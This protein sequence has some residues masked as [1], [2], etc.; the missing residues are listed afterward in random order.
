MDFKNAFNSYLP[1]EKK[2][3]LRLIF[4]SCGIGNSKTTLSKMKRINKLLEM[5]VLVQLT[6]QYCGIDI[7]N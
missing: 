5:S 3:W 6:G 1:N 2:E 4:F 7:L